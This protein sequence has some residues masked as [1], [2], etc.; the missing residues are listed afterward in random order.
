MAGWPSTMAAETCSSDW[1]RSIRAVFFQKH[2]VRRRTNISTKDNHHDRKLP[3]D[4]LESAPRTELHDALG[5]TGCEVS[6]NALPAGAAVPFVHRHVKNEEVY[7]VLEGR[8]ELFIDGEVFELKAGDWFRI[9]PE[10]RRAIRAA[11][12]QASALSA[13]RRRRGASKDSPTTTASPATKRRPGSE[14]T[15]IHLRG[16]FVHASFDGCAC[17]RPSSFCR[18]SFAPAPSA[19]SRG[20]HFLV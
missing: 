11:A 3:Q 14:P 7:G 6:V 20:R 18:L 1:R 12:D 10:G 13:S 17:G 9:S 2:M 19:I 16:R 4:S 15:Q 5:L 8:G